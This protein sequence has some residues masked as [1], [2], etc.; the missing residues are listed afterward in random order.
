MT[1]VAYI[2]GRPGPHPFHRRLG[3][4]VDAKFV[5]V[6]FR[7]RW[8]DRETW[9]PYRYLS[10]AT[11][12]LSFPGRRDYDIFLTDG[13]QIPPLILKQLGL[14]RKN[15]RVVALM[16]N[17][18]LYFLKAGRYSKRS[19]RAILYALSRFDALI[20]LGAYQTEL[21][22]ELLQAHPRRPQILTGQEGIFD[23][24]GAQL[25]VMTPSLYG[26]RL[27]FI[28]N[29][30]GGWGTFYK[31]ADLLLD[32]FA[33]AASHV[34]ELTLDIVGHW[35]QDTQALL[36]RRLGTTGNRVQ[37]LGQLSDLRTPLSMST[38]YVHLGRGD[39]SPISVVEAMLAGLPALVSDQTG[40]RDDVARVDSQ[41]VVP[42]DAAI[43]ADRIRWYLGLDRSEKL[44]LSERSR[45]V[46]AYYSEANAVARFRS[47]IDHVM[48][49]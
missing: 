26:H 9:R 1:K 4:A 33:L 41:L 24:V 19:T 12:A 2:Y 14:L 39:A 3:E 32:A 15:Q 35:D 13:P 40:R 28:G 20:C 45:Q 17:E 25:Q 18:M 7:L 49:A 46:A 44:R 37:F 6:D 27:L 11:C 8:H 10:W 22:H 16:A 23:K 34:P 29:C 38:L 43:A 21:A 42:L 30:H 36:R 5:P 47:M 48:C 31:G